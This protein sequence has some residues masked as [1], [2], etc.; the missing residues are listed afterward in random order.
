M[1]PRDNRSEGR[2]SKN[3]D[4]AQ[5]AVTETPLLIPWRYSLC[6][7]NVCVQVVPLTEDCPFSCIED[8]GST[9]E[10]E[11]SPSQ[12]KV[13]ICDRSRRIGFCNDSINYRLGPLET[14]H[15]WGVGRITVANNHIFSRKPDPTCSC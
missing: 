3:V 10:V 11:E 7:P 1:G 8:L 4:V 14:P 12:F 9:V 15:D 5:I 13:R 2:I 6:V